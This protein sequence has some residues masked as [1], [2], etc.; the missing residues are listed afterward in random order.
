MKYDIT[1][2]AAQ[3]ANT[4]NLFS[5]EAAAAKVAQIL[6][7]LCVYARKDFS[8][9]STLICLSDLEITVIIRILRDRF[10]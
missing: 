6:K 1:A 9:T 7:C 10:I 5:P 2:A 4:K 8:R 3:I